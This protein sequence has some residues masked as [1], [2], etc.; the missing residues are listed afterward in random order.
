MVFTDN[1]QN[2][3]CC[4]RE[5]AFKCGTK[6]TETSQIT[7]CLLENNLEMLKF[8]FRPLRGNI[9]SFIANLEPLLNNLER[10]DS[11]EKPLS[12]DA[13]KVVMEAQTLARESGE[14]VI[15]PEHLLWGLAQTDNP[16]ADILRA[17]GICGN[18]LKATLRT[19][20]GGSTR[21]G[22]PAAA[23][24]HVQQ[25]QP[26]NSQENSLPGE[27]SN[28][29]I[30]L[31]EEAR[32]GRIQP[33][34]GR[35]N[36]IQRILRSL[37]RKSKN[38]PLLIGKPGTG[39]TAIVEGIAHRIVR[40]D[41]PDELK[42]MRLLSLDLLTLNAGCSMRGEFENRMKAI[43]QAVSQQPD[44][45]LFID[46]IHLLMKTGGSMDAASILKP[47]MS[48]GKLRILGATTE[49]EYRSYI[50]SDKAFE[51]RFQKIHVEEPDEATAIS[52]LRSARSS[53]EEHFGIKIL[54]E[55]ITTAVRLSMRYI[56]DR[57]LPDKA[58]DV[59]EESAA[60]I[61]IEQSSFPQ[62][63]DSIIRNLRQKEIELEALKAE[64]AAGPAGR[65]A[66]SQQR[67]HTE[68]ENLQRELESLREKENLL[69]AQWQN[70][71]HWLRQQQQLDSEWEHIATRIRDAEERRDYPQVVALQRR[72][73][74]IEQSLQELR[75][76]PRNSSGQ[77]LLKAAL[78]A[79]AVREAIS[80]MTGI[81]V[82]RVSQDEKAQLQQLQ[83]ILQQQVI[84]QEEAV[85]AVARVVRRNRLGLNNENRPIGSFLFIGPS[86][87][88]KTELAKCLAA[89][90]FGDAN[91]MTRIDMS[92]YQQEFSAT[93]LFG[94]PPGYVGYDRGGQLTESILRKPYSVILLDEIEKAHPRIF[95][96][97]L[98]VLDDGRMTDGQGTVV[99]FR[100]TIIIMT[101]NIGQAEI[102]NTL[103]EEGAA[104]SSGEQLDR[105]REGALSILRRRMAPEFINRIDEIV[106]FRPLHRDAI[107]QIIRV[108]LAAMLA[109]WTEK[110]EAPVTAEAAVED[111]LLE[112]AYIPAYGARP[113][114]RAID[115]YVND[116]LVDA[117]AGGE[118][119]GGQAIS[120]TLP[121]SAHAGER[122]EFTNT[123]S[124]VGEQS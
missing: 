106:M 19:Y 64:T 5:L 117:L 104:E 77:A 100:N 22:E 73:E 30:D 74:E 26:G 103:D 109:K 56:S 37:C 96:T 12:L 71:K 120:I 51:R 83:E 46:E 97:L 121:T 39:K 8:V 85:N 29:T 4:A 1:A 105:A 44:I 99:N 18:E 58:I 63:L 93:R 47:E 119:C 92:E 102:L 55:A 76:Q 41:V 66:P 20:R 33:A 57:F 82:S 21:Q 14:N 110:N 3:L 43:I 113:V 10:A 95:E 7:L 11:G 65:S 72:R 75:N 35:D 101:S 45:V 70:E 98:Q 89:H 68:I 118:L 88:G 87:T 13:R 53:M 67:C 27:L 2:I 59:L 36:E 81:P 28:Y 25:Q 60:R 107:R 90:L 116:G 32:A 54:D 124:Q 114:N 84:G 108:K 79:H 31:V 48:R 40:N 111:F 62:E 112:R 122:L 69:N 24:P 91:L 17:Q 23:A 16:V 15:A 123:A 61:K 78:D 34:L 38:N 9:S 52:I 80:E 115:R 86:G 50:S 42:R 49:D 6:Y 94:A